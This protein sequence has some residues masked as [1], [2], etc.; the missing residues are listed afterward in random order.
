MRN[1]HRRWEVRL[2]RP[3]PAFPLGMFLLAAAVFDH[4]CGRAAGSAAPAGCF[5]RP[6]GHLFAAADGD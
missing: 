3:A 4:A 6:S 5:E 1:G 2:M